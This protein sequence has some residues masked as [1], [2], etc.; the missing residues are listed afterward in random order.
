MTTNIRLKSLSLKEWRQFDNVEIDFHPKLTILT[1]PNGSGKSTILAVVAHS[2]TDDTATRF[3]ATPVHDEKTQQSSFSLGTLFDKYNPF[4]RKPEE[5]IPPHHQIGKLSYTDNIVAD[6]TIPNH[7]SLQYDVQVSSSH[8][9]PGFRIGS[10]TA[11]PTYQ[12]VAYL[13]VSGILP[14]DALSTIGVFRHG[15][16]QGQ[17]YQRSVRQ[18]VTNPVAPLKE[19]LISFAAFG[20][21]NPNMRATPELGRPVRK[22]SEKTGI[23]IARGNLA[24]SAW[25]C[26]APK[27]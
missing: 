8:H 4:K 12:K 23:D 5:P 25:K 26:G 27:L 1:G 21:S 17:T 10:H 13:P 14:K 19:T 16:D 2:L 3:L 15:F 22:F 11:L 6:I 20:S 18:P 7:N 24:S 9:I